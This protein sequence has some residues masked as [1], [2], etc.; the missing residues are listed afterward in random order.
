[1]VVE[2]NETKGQI[3]KVR[4][5][6][7]AEHIVFRLDARHQLFQFLGAEF[8]AIGAT[9]GHLR[10]KVFNISRALARQRPLW[11]IL[12]IRISTFTP[13]RNKKDSEINQEIF[14]KKRPKLK[15]IQ[16]KIKIDNFK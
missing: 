3:V 4:K 6:S 8:A 14:R 13:H 16:K 5:C 15:K 7:D 12:Y 2:S 9:L 11:V 10:A 1:M